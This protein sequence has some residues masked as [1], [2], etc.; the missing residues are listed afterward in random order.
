MI[1][2][3][4]TGA[5]WSLLPCISLAQPVITQ[6]PQDRAVAPGSAVNFRVAASSQ[7]TVYYQWRFNGQDVPGATKRDLAFRATT[8]RA[9]S[10]A[11]SVRDASGER[12][13]APAQLQ[14]LPRP[15]VLV[16]PRNTVVGIGRTMAFEVALNNSGPYTSIDWH[17]SNPIEGPHVIPD[18]LGADVHSTRLVV[19]ECADNP[20]YEGLYWISVTNVVGG[21]VSRRARLTVVGPPT[22][23]ENPKD[24]SILAGQTAR[25]RV[26]WAPDQ[27]PWKTCQWFKEDTAIPGATAR[28][29]I[30]RQAQKTD[31]GWYWCAVSSVGGTSDSSMVELKILDL[32]QL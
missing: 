3:L 21:T 7:T 6:E 5:V 25:F 17:N 10:Y 9:G 4:I 13:S 22:L 29:L 8:V 18:G 1:K 19:A 31:A 23:V 15:R 12:L 2:R 20:I 30:I 11:V 26:A 14:V 28:V 24:V 27:A 16:Q 32:S